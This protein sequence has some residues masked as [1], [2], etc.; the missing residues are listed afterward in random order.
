MV[1]RPPEPADRPAHIAFMAPNDEHLRPW[2]P[3]PTPGSTPHSRFDKMLER[4][5]EAV[6]TG[7]ELRLF[8]FSRHASDSGALVGWF[9]LNNV[10][11]GVFQN[12]YAGWALG[13]DRTGRGLAT[14][15]VLAL[16]DIAL[17]PGPRGMGLHRVQANIMPANA[18]SL[19]VAHR[20]GFRNEGL[21]RQYLE[22]AG[23]W[24]DHHMFAKL[25][26]EHTFGPTELPEQLPE[27]LRR[28]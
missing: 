18:P 1:L 5:D 12:A 17:A 6:A 25:A 4:S 7:R 10:A 21:C 9:N 26:S 16:L 11:R 3:A 23:N 14:E 15:G 13:H 19:A 8:A 24:E 28:Q 20:C 27:V 22:I 2:Q